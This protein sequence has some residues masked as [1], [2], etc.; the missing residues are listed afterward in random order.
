MIERN[1]FETFGRLTLAEVKAWLTGADGSIS[2]SFE[3]F[4]DADQWRHEYW[5]THE[6][7]TYQKLKAWE[8]EQEYRVVLTDTFHDFS[9]TESRKLQYDPKC[10]RGIIFGIS[11]PEADKK[12]VMEKLIDRKDKYSDF[13]FYQQAEFDNEN[14]SITIREKTSQTISTSQGLRPM[15]SEPA[16]TACGSLW[17][18]ADTRS[19][20]RLLRF[21]RLPRLR[22]RNFRCPELCEL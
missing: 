21:L 17:T 13:T 7:K 4:K 11:T 12:Q 18:P 9:T 1:F 10:L 2:S 16:P 20:L 6:I 14:Q 3:V 5:K 22:F 8:S 15:L 19:V